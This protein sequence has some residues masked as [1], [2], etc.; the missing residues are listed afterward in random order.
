MARVTVTNCEGEEIVIFHP[1]DD[2]GDLQTPEAQAKA[3]A[4]LRLAIAEADLSDE[5]AE[6]ASVDEPAG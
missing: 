3:L 4:D 6:S 1:H 5:T 2:W